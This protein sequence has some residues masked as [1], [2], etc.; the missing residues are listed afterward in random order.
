[1]FTGF[2]PAWT[3]E[4]ARKYTFMSA[5]SLKSIFAEDDFSK[6]F[7]EVR[8]RIHRTFDEYRNVEQVD[9]DG[10][11]EAT[12]IIAGLPRPEIRDIDSTYEDVGGMASGMNRSKRPKFMRKKKASIT[13]VKDEDGNSAGKKF[14]WV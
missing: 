14:N 5:F 6:T 3:D 8:A 4:E 7:D 10:V 9:N 11:C 13:D 2:Q 1:M 12:V